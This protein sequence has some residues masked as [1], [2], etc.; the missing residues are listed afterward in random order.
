MPDWNSDTELLQL[1]RAEL[2]TAV[3][4]DICDDIGLRDCFLPP[5][6]RPLAGRISK[7][8]AGRAMPVVEQD[9]DSPDADSFGLMFEALDSLQPDE[10]YLSVGATRPYALFG[11]LMSITAMKRGA[12]GAVCDG[13]IRDTESILSLGFPVFCHGSYSLDQ[14]GRGIVTA[15]RVPVRIGTLEISPGDILVG[16]TD[17]VIAVPRTAEEQV[18]TQALA[19]ARTENRIKEALEQGSSATEAFR[20]FGMF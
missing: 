11:E 5:A 8:M 17:G 12:A 3:I 9:I 14:R 15:Y 2:F 18:F 13:N 19:K 20:N 1:I 7:V 6:I 10:I 4:G 16:D